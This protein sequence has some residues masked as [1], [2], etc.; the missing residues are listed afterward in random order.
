MRNM[1]IR[2]P[3]GPYGAPSGHRIL[4]FL[5]VVISPYPGIPEFN[6]P[7]TFG[8]YFSGFLGY[9]SGILRGLI[10]KLGGISWFYWIFVIL[11]RRNPQNHQY[12]LGNT[13][14]P[15][16]SPNSWKSWYFMIFSVP[17]EASEEPWEI[18]EKYWEI[19][20]IS[21]I[22]AGYGGFCWNHYYEKL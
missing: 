9:S 4:I 14:D 22:F 1:R 19:C 2:C 6:P 11:W 7:T 12:S 8:S 3:G 16:I 20:W 17:E 13:A 10:W 5:I 21:W 18:S 15:E